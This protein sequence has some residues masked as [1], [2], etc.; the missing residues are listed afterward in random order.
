MSWQ[1]G[2][3]GDRRRRVGDDHVHPELWSEAD[4]NRFE[5]RLHQDLKGIREELKVLS[6]ISGGLALA[7]VLGPMV[8]V[9]ILRFLLPP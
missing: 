6:R 2:R 8:V 9:I 3:D 7:A 4:H 5:D 1:R